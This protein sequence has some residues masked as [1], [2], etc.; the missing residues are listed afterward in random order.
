MST[1]AT[2][3]LNHFY[4]VIEKEGDDI[5][6]VQPRMETN[7]CVLITHHEDG[8]EYDFWRKKNDALFELIEEL[9]DEQLAE[10]E[11]LFDTEEGYSDWEADDWEEEH[12]G[13]EA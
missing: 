5:A 1:Y 11:N 13:K 7:D 6:L 4:L 3:Q 10:Y 9:T 8:E 2:L 12:E